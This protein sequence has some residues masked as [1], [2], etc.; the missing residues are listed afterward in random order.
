MKVH[1][2]TKV[3]EFLKM[4]EELSTSKVEIGILGDS[5]SEIL[6][7]ASVNEFGCSI[8]VTDKMRG[9]LGSQGIHLKASTT[10]INIPE[11]SF[12]R[13]GF[14]DNKSKIEKSAEALLEKVVQLKLPPKALFE[15]IG[16]LAV[17]M[18]QDYLTSV[19]APPNSSA[20]VKMKGSSNPLIDSGRL[21]NSIDYKVVKG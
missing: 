8:K 14:D 4:L 15:T 17:G 5:S 2:E 6:M 11:R 20:T 18:I 16:E 10:S 9:Y 7:I 12:V 3:P 1:D 19:S 13:A 21:R